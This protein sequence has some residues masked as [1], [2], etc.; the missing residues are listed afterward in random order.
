MREEH[1]WKNY[2]NQAFAATS[3]PISRA[4]TEISND[5]RKQENYLNRDTSF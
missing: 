4:D 2:L 5:T 3:A 1:N